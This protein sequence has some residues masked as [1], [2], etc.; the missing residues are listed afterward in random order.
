MRPRGEFTAAGRAPGPPRIVCLVLNYFKPDDT[1]TCLASLAD[2]HYPNLEVIVL[3]GGPA[4]LTD[5]IQ[6][7]FPNVRAVPL[8]G[9]GGYTGNNN[10]GM[11]LAADLK[12]DWVMLL[13]EDTRLAPDCLA[14][15][16]AV[17]AS[18]PAA[19]ALGPTVCHATEPEVIQSA[20]GR[21]T[22]AWEAAHLD[23][24]APLTDLGR[25]P[26]P[27][28]WLS[29]CAVLVRW[30]VVEELGGLDERFFIYYEEVDWCL[31]MAARGW[32]LLHV[33]GARLW[34]KGVTRDYQPSPTVTY[35]SVRNRL[36]LMKK[37]RAPARAW[38]LAGLELGRTLASWSLR[39]RW[40]AKRPHRDA[41]WRALVDFGRGRTGAGYP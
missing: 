37:H 2:N 22:A 5:D 6:T 17:A 21:L 11:R 9:N 20:G 18:D 13:N 39:P 25:Q 27:V 32:R 3:N 33:P 29:G 34:H 16:M 41:L 35:Y 28:A 30:A 10:L 19:G 31:R 12:P 38:M 15:L 24:N 23:Q 26:R 7:R 1:L 4:S 14:E 36:M 8:T 40:R